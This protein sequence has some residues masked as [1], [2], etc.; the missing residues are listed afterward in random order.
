LGNPIFDPTGAGNN[1]ADID[2][3]AIIN[4]LDWNYVII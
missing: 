2:S 3:I 1:G 4:Y